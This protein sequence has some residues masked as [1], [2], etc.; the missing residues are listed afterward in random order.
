MRRH[1][2]P[3]PGQ[4]TLE[5]DRPTPSPTP[6]A[7]TAFLGNAPNPVS[8]STTG[9]LAD[10]AFVRDGGGF[11]PSDP[12]AAPPAGRRRPAGHHNPPVNVHTAEDIPLPDG[13]SVDGSCGDAEPRV[14]FDPGFEEEAKT[15][16]A[17]CPVREQC[18]NH[19][20]QH[21][22]LTGV[23]GGMT[24]RERLNAWPPV[25]EEVTVAAKIRAGGGR[26]VRVARF[27]SPRA[28]SKAAAR[29]RQLHAA[30]NFEF[31]PAENRTGGSDLWAVD[32]NAG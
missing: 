11:G 27:Q 12:A 8:T 20:R 24:R 22:A 4:L 14:F 29:M 2:R 19:A 18:L 10:N 32:R 16:C 6:T 7:S 21:P 31:I 30:D 15:I 17:G 5:L 23:R 9:T 13:W 1:R 28:A 3:G 25:P 26:K